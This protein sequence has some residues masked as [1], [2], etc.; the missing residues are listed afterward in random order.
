[1]ATKAPT[2]EQTAEIILSRN[3][4]DPATLLPAQLSLFLNA[5]VSQQMR[6]VELWQITSP[7]GPHAVPYT[8]ADTWNVTSLEKEEA[9]AKWRLDEQQRKFREDG[10]YVDQQIYGEHDSEVSG[11]VHMP[12]RAAEPYMI[13]GYEGLA[14]EEYERTYQSEKATFQPMG[15]AVGK[16]QPQQNDVDEWT[17]EMQLLREMSGN[18][19]RPGT[20][21]QLS[22]KLA[23]DPVYQGINSGHGMVQEDDMMM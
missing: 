17:P 18:V 23:T 10:M 19:S 6:L 9:L 15:S 3:G 16:W 1:V 4:I 8:D 2:D 12:N 20:A 11:E 22:Y 14:R 21:N 7:H 13:S 5:E